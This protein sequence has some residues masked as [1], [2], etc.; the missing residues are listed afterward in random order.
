M[1]LLDILVKLVLQLYL[2]EILIIEEYPG[3]KNPGGN[4]LSAL[5]KHILV[6]GLEKPQLDRYLHYL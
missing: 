2:F 3:F 1:S 5:L 6:E 4:S